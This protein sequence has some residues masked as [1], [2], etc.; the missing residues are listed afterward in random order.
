MDKQ[1]TFFFLDLDGL[2]VDT[3]RLHYEAYRKM[4]ADRG[5]AIPWDFSAYC[6]RAHRGSNF[7]Q[8][9]LYEE[10]PKLYEQEP[11]WSNLYREK[12]C[13]ILQIIASQGVSL[14]PGVEKLLDWI[15]HRKIRSSIV[16]HSPKALVDAIMYQQPMLS[17][18]PYRVVREDYH[19]PKP[20]P[21]PYL[22]ASKLYTSASDKI[23]GF[24]DTLRGFDALHSAGISGVVI[25][26]ILTQDMKLYLQGKNTPYFSSWE[27][28]LEKQG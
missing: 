9:G 14:M 26:S 21:D 10:L 2:L 18:I 23:L 8:K 4:C 24:E 13:A 25:S 15:I 16:T 27:E 12:Q 6:E 22:T 1:Y 3:E 28:Y 11:T 17:K 19:M 7:V 5:F 20:F